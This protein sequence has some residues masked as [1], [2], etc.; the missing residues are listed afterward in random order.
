MSSCPSGFGTLET[1]KLYTNYNINT[2]ELFLFFVSSVSS[3]SSESSWQLVGVARCRKT[4]EGSGPVLH[5]CNWTVQ[6]AS[7]WLSRICRHGGLLRSFNSRCSFSPRCV[8]FFFPVDKYPNLFTTCRAQGG[9]RLWVMHDVALLVFVFCLESTHF[10]RATA[11]HANGYLRFLG[12]SFRYVFWW[13]RPAN[14]C[15]SPAKIFRPP[16]VASTTI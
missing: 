11:T 1:P 15:S 2:I 13:R 12:V 5:R 6:C 14:A 16:S 7:V 3:V 10:F 4:I 9:A 8:R